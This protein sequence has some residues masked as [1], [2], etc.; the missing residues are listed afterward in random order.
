MKNL[1]LLG[2][3]LTV[4]SI[5]LHAE[6]IFPNVLVVHHNDGTE[7]TF[8]LEGTN[9]DFIGMFQVEEEILT[10]LSSYAQEARVFEITHFIPN[11]V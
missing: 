9:I 10:T 4:F 3:T 6:D 11:S 5:T 7:E 1:I 2:I 8:P